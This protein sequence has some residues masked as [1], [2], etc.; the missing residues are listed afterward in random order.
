M[1]GSAE[2]NSAK[3]AG[4]SFDRSATHRSAREQLRHRRAIR[5]TRRTIRRSR[6]AVTK[7]RRPQQ[8]ARI[9]A[10]LENL[11]VGK[12]ARGRNINTRSLREAGIF[13]APDVYNCAETDLT[14]VRGIG[15]ASARK[16]KELAE[17]YARL[18]SEDLRPPADPDNWTAS[19]LAPSRVASRANVRMTARHT[20][21]RILTL[22][23][24]H[25]TAAVADVMSI[26][27][28]AC[29]DR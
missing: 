5:G 15:P 16:L 10:R 7:A 6:K 24:R 18:R 12:L 20:F 11:P 4:R 17:Q 27:R 26:S 3:D 13:S 9:Q 21:P 8:H 14:R 19:N 1:V 2:T 25:R 22:P 29:Q 23:S 28:E